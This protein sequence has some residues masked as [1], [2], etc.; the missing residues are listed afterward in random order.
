MADD[1]EAPP[2]VGYGKPPAAS[3][4]RPGQSGNTKGRPKGEKNTATIWNEELNARIPVTENGKRKTIS[5]R[6]AY[7]KQVTNKAASGDLKAVATIENQTRFQESQAAGAPTREVL[8]RNEDQAVMD[9]ILERLRA[10]DEARRT[11][12]ALLES[13]SP[14]HLEADL[15]APAAQNDPNSDSP[16]EAPDAPT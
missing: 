10:A 15:E 4:F 5:K 7:I 1:R 16:K 13:S 6:R 14:R 3:R 12:E 9:G 11:S 2:K 8:N